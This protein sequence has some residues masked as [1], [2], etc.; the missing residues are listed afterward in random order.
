MARSTAARE[1]LIGPTAPRRCRWQPG[2]HHRMPRAA[3][4]DLLRQI[5]LGAQEAPPSRLHRLVP[6]AAWPA[7]GVAGGEQHRQESERLPPSM[8]STP[9]ANGR[10]RRKPCPEYQTHP[11]NGA[12]DRDGDRHEC[13]LGIF[14]QGES[15]GGPLPHDR[16]ELDAQGIIDLLKD[17][18]SLWTGPMPIPAPYRPPGNLVPGKQTPSSCKNPRSL[19]RRP[20]RTF[21]PRLSSKPPCEPPQNLYIPAAHITPCRG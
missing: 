19:N 14:G 12:S 11:F 20:T 10:Q 21:E 1:P 18:T 2:R 17:F 7:P 4:R 16:T 6:R 5:E 15:F 9:P 13:R 3:R 8:R